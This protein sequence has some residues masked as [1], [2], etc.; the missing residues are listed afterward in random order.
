MSLSQE[1]VRLAHIITHPVRHKIAK[2]LTNSQKMYIA[3]MSE[4]LDVDRKVVSFHLRV[5]E[6]DGLLETKLETKTPH[7][8]NPVLVRYAWLT[9]KTKEILEKCHL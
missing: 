9:D 6:R 1:D 3:Q 2:L 4:E 7:V 8:G 5:M